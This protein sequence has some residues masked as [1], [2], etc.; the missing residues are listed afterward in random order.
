M[1]AGHSDGYFQIPANPTLTLGPDVR[2]DCETLE[3][4][5]QCGTIRGALSPQARQEME[6]A[7]ARFLRRQACGDA[8]YGTTTGFGPFVRYASAQDGNEL[9]GAGLIAHLSAGWG[10]PAPAEIVR[11]A[12]LL[13]AQTLAQGWSGVRVSVV[14]AYL[15]LLERGLVPAVPEIGSVGASGDLIPLAHIA[16][17]LTG[18][19]AVLR[20]ER[21]SFRRQTRWARR[22][23]NRWNWRGA[24]PLP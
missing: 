7:R 24:T 4:A 8:I 15:A 11:A 23:W 9:H 10:P 3:R 2:L 20:D 19:G 13:R 6:S 22:D 21:A 12:M 16:R 5:A 17:V 1:A 14:E 18:E